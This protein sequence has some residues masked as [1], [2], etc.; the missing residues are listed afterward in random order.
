[1]DNDN[2]KKLSD[3]SQSAIQKAVTRKTLEHPIV[4]Y[5]AVLSVLGGFSL[6]LFGVSPWLIGAAAGGFG[7]AFLSWLV[8]FSLRRDTFASDYVKA[9]NERIEKQSL[10]KKAQLESALKE[11]A[12]K[13]GEHQFQRFNEK[14]A[15]FQALLAKKLNPSEI[16]YGR[17]LGMA[18]QVYLGA[19][20]NL[21]AIADGLKAM[22]VI[23]I[24]YIEKRIIE[25][26]KSKRDSAE[27]EAKGLEDIN[28]SEYK[29]LTKRREIF[30]AQK[31]K[32]D[33]FLAQNEEALTQLD[34]TIASI[35]DLRTN[36]KA[37][38][39]DLETAMSEL[40]QL[41]SRTHKY[42]IERE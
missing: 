30:H 23:D 10:K 38:S 24:R 31:N 18:E 33:K 14:F 37:A 12:S 34:I 5:P 17:Y 41:A 1:M 29:A 28:A 20:D 35:A 32:V 13:Q 16:T 39:L 26:D 4:V 3:F 42:S 2:E 15:M 21:Q 36:D 8:N 6:A 40:Q 25:L 9:L 19:V 11:V 22:Q 7:I 27:L